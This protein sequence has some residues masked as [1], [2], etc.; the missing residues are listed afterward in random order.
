MLATPFFNYLTYNNV[1]HTH[2]IELALQVHYWRFYFFFVVAATG[3]TPVIPVVTTCR[4]WHLF[5]FRFFLY[6]FVLFV[7]RSWLFSYWCW[8]PLRKK[9]RIRVC[10]PT[11]RWCTSVGVT[12]IR[13]LVSVVKIYV[14]VSGT[15]DVLPLNQRYHCLSD[16]RL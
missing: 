4:W 2:K 13:W 8:C 7:Y 10:L 6:K 9:I 16:D 11:C 3:Y 1:T 12:E 5:L 15:S 14:F